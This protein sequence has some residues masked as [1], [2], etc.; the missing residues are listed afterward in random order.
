M[1]RPKSLDW[2]LAAIALAWGLAELPFT[3]D[4]RGPVAVNV[5]AVAAIA[6]PLAWWRT[7]PL[8]ATAC[9]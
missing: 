3:Q 5:V 6:A 8:R 7:F 1:R 4:L 2:T 9:R